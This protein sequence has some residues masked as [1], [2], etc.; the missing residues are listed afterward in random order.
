MRQKIDPD[1]VGEPE[2][3]GLGDA[4]RSAHHRV[5]L[6]DGLAS[7]PVAAPGEIRHLVEARRLHGRGIGYVDV[8]LL[9]ACL[10]S[11]GTRLWTRDRR[12]LAAAEALAVAV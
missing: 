4:E 2:N 10:L 3:A 6:L 5:G 9:A 11:P 1:E 12:L 7:L 8:A